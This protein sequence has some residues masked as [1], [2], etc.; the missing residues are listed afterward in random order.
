MDVDTMRAASCKTI[1]VMPT[2]SL[3]TQPDASLVVL[4][5]QKFGAGSVVLI[6]MALGPK[7][8]QVVGSF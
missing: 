2:E 4:Q 8:F 1:D 7:K 6:F 3:V 5:S